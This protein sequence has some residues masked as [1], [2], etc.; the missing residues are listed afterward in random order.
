LIGIGFTAVQERNW[1]VEA[2][3]DGN[4]Y[5]QAYPDSKN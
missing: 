5:T 4:G 1:L 2:N 3:V